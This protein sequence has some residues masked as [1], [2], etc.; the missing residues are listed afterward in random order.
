M[1]FIRI[2][3]INGKEY[4]YEE[5][6]WRGADGK[7]KS[8]SIYL[9][10]SG[11]GRRYSIFSPVQEPGLRY[12]ERWMERDAAAARKAAAE[13]LMAE[14][15]QLTKERERLQA[16]KDKL[17]KE[18]GV[19]FGPMNPTPVEKT[20]TPATTPNESQQAGAEATAPGTDS[21]E[22]AGDEGSGSSA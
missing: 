9:G 2:R 12:I 10:S 8:R 13:Q 18:L 4:V 21:D 19:Q 22:D 16:A 20:S 15:K 14:G 6:R 17:S 3:T 11:A 1:A 7:V 5:H